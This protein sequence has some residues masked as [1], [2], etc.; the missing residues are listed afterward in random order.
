M[1]LRAPSQTVT[2]SPAEGGAAAAA[3]TQAAS[4][5]AMVRRL[6]AGA[7]DRSLVRRNALLAFAVRVA[8]AGLLYLSQIVLARWM[9]ASE[10]GAYVLAWTWVL[11]LGGLSHLGLSMTNIRLLPEYAETGQWGLLRGLLRGGRLIALGV[12]SVVALAGIA[13][14]HLL[15][16][17]IDP[18]TAH[19]VMLAMACVP[20][21]ALTDLQ[22]GIG[23][24]RGW[25][26]IALVPP[27]IIRP[28]L[29][30]GGMIIAHELGAAM[31]AVTAAGV[32]IVATT[33]AALIQTG[34]VERRLA[35]EVP[36]TPRTYAFK[37][38]FAISMPLLVIYGAELVMQNADVL[39]LA[40]HR[41]AAE[42]GMYFAAAKTMALVMFVHY[43]VGS[44]AAHRFSAL[45]AR[46]DDAGLAR[47][48]RDG[49]RWTFLPSLAAAIVL[50]V[51]GKPL[52]WLFSPEFT[53]AYPV[54]AILVV[55]FLARASVGPAE[56]LLNMLGQQRAVAAVA[57]SAAVFDIALC[58]LLIPHFGMLGAAIANAATLVFAAI[59]Y[60]IVAYR[61]L[62]MNIFVLAHLQS[63]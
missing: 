18:Q 11:V 50:L 60:A 24:G 45:K 52:L 27:Y 44:A 32:A 7:T 10:F 55:G 34:L 15:G 22:D 48:V 4:P 58:A 40:M 41:P 61:R 2:A 1:S 6:F 54:M 30:L 62:G 36:K 39:L 19:A 12:G 8:S 46:G 14:V 38:W 21:Y 31:C 63:K 49:V 13:T 29:L 28:A 47:A 5:F 51:L 53:S 43:A 35:A 9:G 42:V 25:I 59:A 17:R 20:L 56:F 16:V 3:P 57:V 23:R 26:G 37:T 33:G